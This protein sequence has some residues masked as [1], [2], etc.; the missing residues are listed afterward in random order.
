MLGSFAIAQRTVKGKVTDASSGEALIGANV[1]AK[2]TTS[3]AVTDIDGMYSVTLPAS[4]T[5]LEV[6][7][8]GY[9]T[10]TIPLGTSN[11][12]DIALKAGRILEDVVVVGYGSV[13]KSDATGAVAA[14]TEKDFNKG[15]IT[16]PEQ[17]MQGRVAGVQIAQANGEP[18]GGINVRIRGTSSVRANNNPLFVIDGVPLAGDDVSGGGIDAGFGTGA[19]KNPL[20]YLNPNDI[21]KIDILKDAS[22]TAIYG[23][24]GANGVVLITTKSGKGK[25]SLNYGYSLGV[26]NITKKYDLLSADEFRRAKPDADL[27]GNTDWQNE[28]LRTALTHNHDI[29]YGAGSEKGSYRVSFNYMNQDGI[30]EQSNFKR[31]STR[32]NADHLFLNNRLKIGVQAAVTNLLD[33]NVP[34]SENSGFEG[35]LIGAMVKSNPTM[36]AYTNGDTLT[37]ISTTEPSPLAYLRYSK[38]NTNTLRTQGNFN[39]E[40][41]IFD[42]LTF[43]S[44]IGFDRSLS[45][46]KSAFSSD[47]K[48]ARI[49]QIGRMTTNDVGAN[50]NTFDNYF[51]YT[52]K[53]GKIDFTGLAGYSYQSFNNFGKSFI[54]ARFRTPDLNEMINNQSSASLYAPRNSY[55]TKDELQSY[56]GRVNFGFDNKYLFTATFR[57]DGST[58]FGEN[59]RYGYFPSL[60]GKWRLIQENFIPKN[61]FSD[62]ALRASWGVT[63][64]QELPNNRYTFRN[65]FSDIGFNDDVNA[66]NGNGFAI[67]A[68][69]NPN[70]KWETTTQVNLGLDF[71]FVNNRISGTV[72]FYDKRTKDL[73]MS[74]FNPQPSATPFVWKNLDADI[75]NRG[76][77][78]S[79]N[80]VAVSTKDFS[81]DV[82]FN[83]AHNKNLIKR[84]EGLYNTGRINGQGL[85]GAFAQ[86]LSEGEPMF[87]F[88][89]RDFDGFSADGLAQTYVNGLDQQIFLDGKSPLPTVTGGITNTLRYKKFDASVFFNGV[90]GNY[91]YNNTAN[92]FFTAGALGSGRNVTRDVIGNGENAAN[93]PDVSDRFLEKGD[94]VRLANAS[95]GYSWD[96]GSKYISNIRLFANGQNLLT[97]TKYSGQDPEVSTNKQIDGIP[98]F[99]IDYT[100]FPRARTITFGANVTF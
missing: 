73:L 15:V 23:A 75:Q 56:F 26:S 3:G 100:A 79:L 28:I 69:G 37:Q 34:I 71:G 77:E 5:A 24:R 25:G 93:S 33:T 76:I 62:L 30:I 82:N 67:I 6:S 85:S 1:V 74:V 17:L 59:N 84:L 66:V 47:F 78:L 39:A 86:Q 68:T 44:V 4:A 14:V 46:R 21:E 52:K 53:A 27:G 13:K 88:F 57:A 42:G 54:L 2:G 19:P 18:G 95:I 43:K 80:I 99:G 11:V 31:Y 38:D 65:R 83:V 72:E 35:D 96:L 45:E 64:N 51:T 90:F 8:A 41:K 10:Q 49:W 20:N 58:R 7:Y 87:A 60:A 22:A 29:S 9:E 61:I 91:I 48:N 94:F 40:F 81:W 16:S 97:F 50:N 98:S 12:I 32:F 70:L 63:G 55:N 89:L 36:K 92:A